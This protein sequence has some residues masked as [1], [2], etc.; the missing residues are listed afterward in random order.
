MASPAWVKAGEK[1]HYQLYC[2]SME[3]TETWLRRNHAGGKKAFVASDEEALGGAQE[4]TLL[5]AEKTISLQL[6]GSVRFSPP[7]TSSTVCVYGNFQYRR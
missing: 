5:A 7:T 3:R 2:A 1:V 6:N 4:E